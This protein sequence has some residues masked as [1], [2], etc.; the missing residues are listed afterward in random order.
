MILNI[1]DMTISND[2]KKVTYE[3]RM[4]GIEERY[5]KDSEQYVEAEQVWTECA[6]WISENTE[7]TSIDEL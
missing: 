2:G 1:A 7:I 6:K 5:G 3:E 4:A